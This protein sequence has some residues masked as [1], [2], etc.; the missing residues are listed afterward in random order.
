MSRAVLLFGSLLMWI[1]ESPA[2]GQIGRDASPRKLE[3]ANPTRYDPVVKNIE[4]WAVSVEPALLDGEYQAET[5]RTG[6]G[7]RTRRGAGPQEVQG[8]S[9]SPEACEREKRQA[10]RRGRPERTECAAAVSAQHGGLPTAVHVSVANLRLRQHSHRE[11]FDVLQ[12]KQFANSPDLKTEILNAVMSAL[13]AHTTMSTQ[14]LN[15]ETVRE[16]LKDVLLGPARLYES[17]SSLAT[18]AEALANAATPGSDIDG[19]SQQLGGGQLPGDIACR[20]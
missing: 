15:S 6:G 10:R 11:A 20:K 17:A 8:G 1:A 14:A 3:E 5:G 16:G 12:A 2:G 4:G 7:C 9:S 19:A 13:E 18:A